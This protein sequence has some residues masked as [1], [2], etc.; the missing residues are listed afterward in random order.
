MF[1]QTL[2]VLGGNH[3]NPS[4]SLRNQ[5]TSSIYY[6]GGTLQPNILQSWQ[7]QPLKYY[8][9]GLPAINDVRDISL[10]VIV[11]EYVSCAVLFVL[12]HHLVAMAHDRGNE[13]DLS[14]VA[15]V[16]KLKARLCCR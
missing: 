14:E 6:S 1:A 9:S 7:I 5:N 3:I 4:W 16:I 2:P 12:S 15:S 13:V 10:D 11:E 8:N